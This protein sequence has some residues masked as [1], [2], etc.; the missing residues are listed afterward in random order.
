MKPSDT[1]LGY[2][3]PDS[4]WGRDSM[5][6]GYYAL[7]QRIAL[8]LRGRRCLGYVPGTASWENTAN[9]FGYYSLNGGIVRA[10]RRLSGRS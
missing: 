7:N 6:G 8:A 5:E 2:A 9:D 3:P 4:M 1:C 10:L